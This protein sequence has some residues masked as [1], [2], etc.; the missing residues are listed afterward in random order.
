[1]IQALFRLG[2]ASSRAALIR[3]LALTAASALL[4]AAVLVLIVLVSVLPMVAEYLLAK[5]RTKAAADALADLTQGLLDQLGLTHYAIYVQDYGAPI[6]WRLALNRRD[7]ITAIITQNGNGYDEGFVDSF[8]TTVWDYQREQTAETEAADAGAEAGEAG[9][10]EGEPG[11]SA[12]SAGPSQGVGP[13][14]GVRA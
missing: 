5:R 1:M 12:G 6:G 9:P 2:D 11:A 7:A 10:V 14:G 3:S 8:W 13:Q 4:M